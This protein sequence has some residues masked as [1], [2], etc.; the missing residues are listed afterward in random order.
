[1]LSKSSL[2]NDDIQSS[3]F[4]NS[5]VILSL[6]SFIFKSTIRLEITTKFFNKLGLFSKSHESPVHHKLFNHIFN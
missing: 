4:N 6:N 1:M 2:L 3:F 5:L